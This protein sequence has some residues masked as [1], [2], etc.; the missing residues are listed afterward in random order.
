MAD[1]TV[2][3]ASGGPLGLDPAIAAELLADP[4]L[5]RD[6]NDICDCGGRLAGT[7]SEKRAFALLRERVRA[8]SPANSGRSIPVPYGGWRAKR[9]FLRLPDG[10]LAAC[11]PLVRT[12][13]TPPQG[14][15]AEV[16]D[17][18]RGTPEEF[19]AHAAEIGGRIVLVRHELMFAAGTIHRRRKYDAARAH[20]AAG[21]LIAGPLLGHV[22]AG[23]SG[24]QAGD[25]IPALGIAPETAARLARRAKGYPTVTMTIETEEGPAETETLLY[26]YPGRTGEWVVLSAH[27]DG[28]DLAESAMDNGTGLAS[29]LAVTR[30]LAPHVAGFRRGLRVMFFSVEEWALTGSAQYVESLGEAERRRIALNVNLDSVAGSP[31]L[32]AL[33]SGFGGVEP[34]VLDVAEANGLGVRTV[35]PL[36]TNSDHANF[37]QAGIPALRLVAGFDDPAANLRLVLTPADTRDKIGQ[38]ELRTATIFTAAL[39]AA[40]CNADPAEVERWRS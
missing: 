32:A 13:A 29:V 2:S 37:A 1:A 19:E 8:A 9:A 17:L 34:F 16:I 33:T 12:I 5:W 40:A 36:M 38:G 18:G 6:F 11:H 27:V 26:D 14:L 15:T 20:G 39:V 23:S 4:G 30:A 24:R 10:S 3:M 22:V 25:G 28:H 35:R 21:F 7:E 31:N